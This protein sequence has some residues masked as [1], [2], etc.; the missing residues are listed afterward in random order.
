MT[1]RAAQHNGEEGRLQWTSQG[2]NSDEGERREARGA[3]RGDE[4]QRDMRVSEGA[5]G[6]SS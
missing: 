2:D 5:V 4:D 6:K 3:G 1:L